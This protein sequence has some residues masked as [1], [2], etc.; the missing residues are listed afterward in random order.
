MK[1]KNHFLILLFITAI[2][3]ISLKAQ[4][5]DSTKNGFGKAKL[6]LFFKNNVD[7]RNGF[8]KINY[9]FTEKNCDSL[10]LPKNCQNF[11]RTFYDSFNF[12][13]ETKWS[14]GQPWGS[15]HPDFQ[16]QYY[17]SKQ[18]YVKDG[19]LHL[20]NEYDPQTFNK[21][22]KDSLTIPYGT[23]LINSLNQKCF[24]YG[25]FAVRSKNPVGPAT[26]PAFWLT[27]KKNWPPEIDIFEMYGKSKGKTIHRQTMT[28]HIGK[29]ETHTKKMVVKSI[30][31]PKDTDTKFHIYGCLWEPKKITFYTDGIKVKTIKLNRWMRQFY[32]E[33]MYLILNNALDHE[34]LEPLKTA[35]MPQD[36]QVDWVQVYQK[37]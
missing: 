14:K 27:G 37:N 28:V 34:H 7:F 31:L 35:Q 8:S 11:K 5:S 25:F 21:N 15:Y 1:V 24:Q 4:N 36:F 3:N 26:W 19:L 6:G 20:L 18:I 22:T 12:F 29:L 16:H 2:G 17:G 13:D 30:Q 23:G 9:R 32:Q 10:I 33:P